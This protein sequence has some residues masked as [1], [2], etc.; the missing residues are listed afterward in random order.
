MEHQFVYP[1]IHW[2]NLGCFQFRAMNEAAL[3]FHVQV[4]YR[5]KFSTHLV[6]ILCITLKYMF[7][8]LPWQVGSQE[9]SVVTGKFGLGAQH[10]AGQRLI[11]FS[12]QNT[13]VIANTFFQQHKRRFYTWTSPDGQYW[14][15][16]QP[17]TEKL[18]IVGKNKTRSWLW[19]RSWTPYCQIQ[20]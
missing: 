16:L 1:L 13:L 5:H 9:I 12:H 18:Y 20:T 10:E 11:E 7:W 6:T 3:D 15:Q 19:L 4:L 17:K 14:N 8:Q 2:K